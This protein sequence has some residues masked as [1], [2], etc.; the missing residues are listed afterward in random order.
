[1]QKS[2]S[3]LIGTLIMAGATTAHAASSVDLSVRGS[4][5][6]SACEMSF[7][8]GGEFDLGKIAAKDLQA[9]GPTQLPELYADLTITCEDATLVAIESKDNRAGSAYFNDAQYFGLG[10]INGVEK[11]GNMW[12]QL[13]SALADGVAVGGIHS[14]DSGLTW[15]NGGYFYP[16]NLVS[17]RIGSGA[18]PTPFQVLNVRMLLAPEIAPASGLTLTSEVP[19]DASI[20]LT[21][22]YL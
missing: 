10:L 19:I 14:I 17:T 1:M 11:L 9:G 3:C 7:A 15:L 5:T 2:L 18:A 8:N 4:I 22:K 12:V 6:P 21:A 13:R 16:G 20:T